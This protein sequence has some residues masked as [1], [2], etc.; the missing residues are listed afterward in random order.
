MG[1]CKGASTV[2]WQHQLGR[3]HALSFPGPLAGRQ[4]LYPC[5]FGDRGRNVE[6]I[7]GVGLV[8]D[9]CSGGRSR[10]VR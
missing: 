8:G 3:I 1:R 4:F 10:P 9:L 7:H 5:M 6:V 2:I